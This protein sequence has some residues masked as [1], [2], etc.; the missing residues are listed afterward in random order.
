M[1]K[2]FISYRRDDSQDVT[3][4]IHDRLVQAFPRA[5]IFIDVD[6][7]PAGTDFRQALEDAVANCDIL[8]AI[9]GPRWLTVADEQ[10]GRR[11]DNPND[12][13]RIE[14]ESA[15]KRG[16]PVI[17]VT[18]S[19]AAI[20]RPQDLPESLRNL[21]FR[22]GR[23]V[24]PNPDFHHDMDRIINEFKTGRA[25][26]RAGPSTP[27][28]N[29]PASADEP[30]EDPTSW[31]D[32][33]GEISCPA[34][35]KPM[36]NT[37]SDLQRRNA[38]AT[39]LTG[40]PPE[41]DGMDAARASTLAEQ[42]VAQA[43]AIGSS[44]RIVD[45]IVAQ[46]T[47]AAPSAR[48]AE[49]AA[50]LPAAPISARSTSKLTLAAVVAVVLAAGLREIWWRAGQ[51][52]DPQPFNSTS[53]PTTVSAQTPVT[54]TATPDAPPPPIDSPPSPVLNQVEEAKVVQS[55]GDSDPNVRWEAIK[56]LDKSGSQKAY[57]VM[58]DRLGHDNDV[59]LKKK[60]IG[61][62]EAHKRP[63][64]VKALKSALDLQGIIEAK[65]GK[66]AMVNDNLVIEG[67]RIWDLAR[68]LT[69]TEPVLLTK[70]GPGH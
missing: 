44:L 70:T 12:F 28:A 46:E 52:S 69:R 48:R 18:V 50:S 63:D 45:Q 67:D 19:N 23:A 60:I 68:T 37:G 20:P 5:D 40:R 25:L 32:A 30:L 9:I 26:R 59:E 2:I 11:L 51:P 38:I 16:I 41:G 35:R 24:R 49:A 47:K 61:L 29:A 4:R 14:V 62:L 42:I 1:P 64:V 57:S 8:L 34:H 10:G 17:P 7:I 36:G 31:T 27:A 66:Q 33:K 58:F 54:Q 21:A 56:L 39:H 65:E 55:V 3:G 13:V 15:L 6:T 53:Q 43:L 22:N